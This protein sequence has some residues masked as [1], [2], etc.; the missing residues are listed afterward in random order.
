ML[1]KYQVIEETENCLPTNSVKVNAFC[2]LKSSAPLKIAIQCYQDISA[3]QALINVK[4]V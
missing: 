3:F 1:Q 4:S 2:P